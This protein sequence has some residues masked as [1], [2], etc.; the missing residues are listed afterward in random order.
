MVKRTKSLFRSRKLYYSLALLVVLAVNVNALIEPVYKEYKYIWSR[1]HSVTSKYGRWDV[2]EYE[3]PVKAVHAAVLKNGSVLLIAGSGNDEAAFDAKSFRTVVWNPAN[4]EFKE[5]PTPWDAFCGGHVFLPDG[6]LLVAGGTRVYEDLTIE[7]RLNY[8]GLKQSYLFNPDTMQYEKVDDMQFARWYP[9]LTNLGDGTVVAVAGLDD[10]GKM[11]SGETEIYDPKTKQ[12]T[13]NPK[14]KHVFPTYPSLTLMNDGR[15]FY[16]GGNQGYVPGQ[17]SLI[18]GIWNLKDNNFQVTPGLPD[19][20]RTDNSATVLLPPAQDQKVFIMGGAK[21]GDSPE[22]ETTNRTAIIDLDASANPAYTPGPN[23]RNATRYPSAVILPDDTVFQTG[24][25]KGYRNFDLFSAQIYN[26]KTNTFSDAASPTVGR[27]Y[28]AESVL[29]PDGRVATFGS[30]PLDGS[31]EMRI[32]IYSPPYLFQGKRPIIESGDTTMAR[33]TTAGLTV[34]VPSSIKTAKLI[35]PSAVT[36]VTDMSQRSVDLPFKKTKTGI[37]VQIPDNPNLLPS[38]WYMAFVTN[39][40]DV[41]STA[42]W[43][44]VP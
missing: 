39:Q 14:L 2:L 22:T 42:F 29:L 16:S 6:K 35:R 30:N 19:A 28:H 12:W 36:H 40:Q 26:P 3:S 1:Q 18:P 25:S 41:P 15:L 23:L 32:E 20:Q 44:H 34:D 9:T 43:V 13:Y 17:A 4:G 33:G 24:G 37:D 10:R 38:G 7:P 21:A 27:N 31:Y 11:S 8:A 5:V